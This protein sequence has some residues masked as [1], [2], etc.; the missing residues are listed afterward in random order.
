MAIYEQTYQAWTGGYGSRLRRLMSMVR[1]G[2]A[3]PFRNVWLLLVIILAWVI[4]AAW[5]MI[6]LVMATAVA[7]NPEAEAVRRM[8]FAMGNNIYRAQFLNNPYFTVILVVLSVAG[9]AALI[10]RDLRHNA[11]LMYFSRAITRGDYVLA[12]FLTLALFLLFV[13]LG[14]ALLMFLGQLG[15]GTEALTPAQRLSDLGAITLH[16]I[17]IVVPMS[18][19]VLA[20]SSLTKRAYFAGLLWAGLFFAGYAFSRI[21][22]RALETDWPGLLFWSNLTSH[23][24][25]FCYASRP[26]SPGGFSGEASALQCGWVEPLAI[27][28]G[29][30]AVSLAI[31]RW[32]VGSVEVRE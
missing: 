17:I 28:A 15:F 27:L 21:L 7:R 23:L 31:V 30:T 22:S 26:G 5:L 2:L 1:P 8:W 3:Q 4:V 12:K 10:S 9:G 24:G 29:V 11:L 19:V 13:T 20:C 16:S 18:A 32:R 25:N 6:L 14:P